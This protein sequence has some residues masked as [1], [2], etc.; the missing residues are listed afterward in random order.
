[1][2]SSEYDFRIK[3][4]TN[5]NKIYFPASNFRKLFAMHLKRLTKNFNRY[6]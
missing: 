5:E 1:M 2:D 4:I 6:A 3:R